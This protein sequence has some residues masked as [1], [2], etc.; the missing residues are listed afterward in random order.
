M[1]DIYS[2]VAG[3]GLPNF[4]GVRIPVPSN[5]NLKA[6][7][8]LAVIQQQ[9]QVME[10][11]TFGFPAGFEGPL[12]TP[13][14]VNHASARAHPQDITQFTITEIGHWVTLLSH[15]SVRS[16]NPLLTQT[17]KDSTCRRVFM[18]FFSWPLHLGSSVNGGTLRDTEDEAPLGIRAG[19]NHPESK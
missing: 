12:P 7:S 2:R 17:K 8:Q 9:C 4:I 15:V 16:I 10:F 11:L 14:T 13:S 1:F 18:D 3:L 6:W 5:L 19:V